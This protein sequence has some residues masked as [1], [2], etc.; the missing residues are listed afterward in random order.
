M[1]NKKSKKSEKTRSKLGGM[2]R[3]KKKV[4]RLSVRWQISIPATFIL[5]ACVVLLGLSTYSRLKD[6]LVSMAVKE[7]KMAAGFA[8]DYLD[9]ADVAAVPDGDESSESYQRVFESL[10]ETRERYDVAYLSTLYT[11]G[12]NVYYG[13]D[14]DESEWHAAIG[15][16]FGLTYSDL[17]TAFNGEILAKDQIGEYEGG[18]YLL[19]AYAPI[20]D[21]SGK[22]VGVVCCDYNVADIQEKITRSKNEILFFVVTGTLITIIILF[23]LTARILK[24]IYSVDDKIYDL[25][26]NE[27][28][29]TKELD[30]RTGDEFELIAGNVNALLKYI[31]S[32]M[33]NISDDS[34]R[35]ENMTQNVASSVEVAKTSISEV[36]ATMEEMTAAMQET[37]ASLMQITGAVDNM[38][39][40]V[41]RITEQAKVGQ[42]EV[43]EIISKADEINSRS[44]ERKTATREEADKMALRINERIEKS[45]A[46]EQISV[47]TESILSITESTNLLALNAS[48]E[49]ARAG[50]AGKGFAVV[51]GEIGK[52]ATESADAATKI[53]QVSEEVVDAVTQLAG[54]SEK[55]LTFL[56]ETA[57]DGFEQ[58]SQLSEEY[59]DDADKMG[60]RMDEFVEA[61]SWLEKEA[62]N[63]QET[64]S[65]V[66]I[67]VEE[68]A[69]GV[70]NVTKMAAELSE[71]AG[72]IEQAA[73]SNKDIANQLNEEVGRFKLN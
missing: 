11:D 26:N 39:G 70:T 47:L 33:L 15:Q 3:G 63:I 4:R 59:R 8:V 27:G 1:G 21:N 14:S 7:A 46:V 68:S 73:E 6:S 29:L 36:S 20:M 22:V 5:I 32:V 42:S 18:I 16:D 64:V 17:E 34:N 12:S 30:V 66:N 48:I 67:A 51:A 38:Y 10:K 9:P 41:G 28:D 24:N 65:S 50:E 37:S 23:L 40:A 72:G 62:G 19:T 58:L 49:A 45:K 13:V 54:E 57:M 56:N 60:K 69:N 44:K 2:I 52:L 25:V 43:V 31:R 35:L 55:M 71:S 53:K 61:S